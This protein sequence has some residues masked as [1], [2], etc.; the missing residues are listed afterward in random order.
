MPPQHL[1]LRLRATRHA[2]RTT[3]KTPPGSRGRFHCSAFFAFLLCLKSVD[4][5]RQ[6]A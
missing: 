6:R 4:G 5:D 2:W 3:N 1:R